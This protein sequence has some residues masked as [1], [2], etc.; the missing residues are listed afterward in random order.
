MTKRTVL[1]IDSDVRLSKSELIRLAQEH[2]ISAKN[3]EICKFNLA[4]IDKKARHIERFENICHGAKFLINNLP[5][6][7]PD[8]NAQ[9]RQVLQ[10]YVD[11]LL[12]EFQVNIEKCTDDISALH[13]VLHQGARKLVAAFSLKLNLGITSSVKWLSKAEEYYL[14]TRPRDDV[15]TLS[16][17]T[18]SRGTFYI[19]QKEAQKPPL[20]E[21]L[22][23][24]Y[25][26]IALQ[27][28]PSP[29]LGRKRLPSPEWYE[30]LDPIEK[31]FLRHVLTGVETKEEISDVIINMSSRLR[32]LPGAA[33]FR[34]HGFYLYDES[35]KELKADERPASSMISSRDAQHMSEEVRDFH[36]FQNLKHIIDQ[37]IEDNILEELEDRQLKDGDVI[38]IKIPALVQTLVSPL[39]PTY[40]QADYKLV[41]DKRRAI[42]K[43]VY[44]KTIKQTVQDSSGSSIDITIE[45]E[46]EFESTNHSLNYANRWDYTQPKDDGCLKFYQN[47]SQFLL[48][49]SKHK[50]WQDIHSLLSEYK[51]ILDIG[52]LVQVNWYDVNMR[53]L[54]L[55]SLEQ[56]IISLQNGVPYGSCVSAKDRKALEFM[57]TDAMQLYKFWY[58]K[59]P[60]YFD[61][62]CSDRDRFV[63]ILSSLYLTR[64]HHVSAS[65]NAPGA[66]G[67]KTPTMYLPSDVLTA[68]ESGYKCADPSDSKPLDTDD[69]LASDNELRSIIKSSSW[70]DLSWP[71]YKLN[72]ANQLNELRSELSK[73]TSSDTM[74]SPSYS[75]PKPYVNA[76]N[77]Y[78][79]RCL[80]I[81][82][83]MSRPSSDQERLITFWNQNTSYKN[84]P[85]RLFGLFNNSRP[86]GVK[87]IGDVFAEHGS[88][89]L[90]KSL[91]PKIFKVISSR[92]KAPIGRYQVT[93]TFYSLIQTLFFDRDSY[94]SI[95]AVYKE[96]IKLYQKASG[97]K[98]TD[99]S[100]EID[101]ELKRALPE[102]ELYAYLEQ[103]TEEKEVE[104]MSASS[105]S[106]EDV[107]QETLLTI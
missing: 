6:D 88:E 106:T 81:I 86:D 56:L 39:I 73:R 35:L 28:R 36:T 85:F 17:I 20:S 91:L 22:I 18:N 107:E 74:R 70:I 78:T 41:V 77:A 104:R 21:E 72:A 84:K 52:S 79:I 83:K 71:S 37:S 75:E 93:K 49:D 101:A 66:E 54:F 47:V 53:E 58:G 31:A 68:I 10:V 65:L 40:F 15:M 87:K 60:S 55:S 105:P 98:L 57:H 102:Q 1:R 50:H 42:D 94:V 30:A 80:E 103:G 25:W 38:Q 7:Y 100:D 82:N 33:N 67:I 11:R 43:M 9:E 45:V 32:T 24:D 89:P 29:D 97:E 23:N 5:Q 14:L 19:V 27:S 12:E 95:R 61:L 51:R 90:D 34:D 96:F 3:L 2:G 16:T 8:L 44:A 59:W 62:S 64:H 92:M 46:V 13:E 69:Q 48:K 4:K 76:I 63:D 26:A 99:Y